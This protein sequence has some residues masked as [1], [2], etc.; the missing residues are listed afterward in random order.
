LWFQ[1]RS[2]VL[3]CSVFR[4]LVVLLQTGRRL[5]ACGSL[6][7][8][9]ILF[10]QASRLFLVPRQKTDESQFFL[11]AVSVFFLSRVVGFEVFFTL[12]HVPPRSL[13]SGFL[14]G[15]VSPTRPV[16]PAQ[17]S[18]ALATAGFFCNRPAVCGKAPVF[19]PGRLS[20][21]VCSFFFNNSAS[22]IL[23]AST[24]CYPPFD[25]VSM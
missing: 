19:C 8:G 10:R 2:P 11:P 13:S 9:G 12:S 25:S 6:F 5:L 21:E 17:I 15:L 20:S 18:P 1:T 24:F 4:F 22:C 3:I 7:C 14:D 16:E 23:S